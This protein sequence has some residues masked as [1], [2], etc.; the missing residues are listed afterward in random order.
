MEVQGGWATKERD[1]AREKANDAQR[2]VITMFNEQERFESHI[3]RLQSDA[4]RA[5]TAVDKMMEEAVRL[6]SKNNDFRD[7]RSPMKQQQ[8]DDDA[9]D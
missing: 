8:E 3:Q 4:H 1:E 2:G 9:V 6:R 5:N 7:E